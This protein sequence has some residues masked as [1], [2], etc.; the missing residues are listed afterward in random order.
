MPAS[1]DEQAAEHATARA[2]RVPQWNEERFVFN[3]RIV[4]SYLYV[5]TRTGYPPDP[6]G[7]FLRPASFR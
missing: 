4:C 6:A 5:I 7:T 3:P 2:A 1:L